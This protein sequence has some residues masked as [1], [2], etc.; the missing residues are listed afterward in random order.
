MGIKSAK[1]RKR[2]D[3][4]QNHARGPAPIIL[5]DEYQEY[6]KVT[7]ICGN[8]RFMVL[9]PDRR[10]YLGILC[11]RLFKRAWITLDQI[12]LVSRRDF[13]EDKVDIIH[14]YRDDDVRTLIQMKELPQA[15]VPSSETSIDDVFTTT[16]A[17][18]TDMSHSGGDMSLTGDLSIDDQPIDFSLV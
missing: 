11:R 4:K 9:L 13:Q 18:G 16:A 7:K 15:L 8:C 3:K 10:E 5:K 12:V 6:G 17:S 2:H 1:A 14:R